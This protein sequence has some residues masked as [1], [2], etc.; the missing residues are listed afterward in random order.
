MVAG[1]RGKFTVFETE[2]VEVVVSVELVK[3][4]VTVSVIELVKIA[5]VYVGRIWSVYNSVITT[6]LP[7][8]PFSSANWPR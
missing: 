3:V 1:K 2:L 5:V 7:S 4:A 8:L 6:I